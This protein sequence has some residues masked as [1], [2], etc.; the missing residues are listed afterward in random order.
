MA[1]KSVTNLRSADKLVEEAVEFFKSVSEIKYELAKDAY[2]AQ[3]EETKAVIDRIHDTLRV[4]ASGYIT[5]QLSPPSGDLVPVKIDND[6]LTYNL[7]WL[8]VEIIK[9][10]AI[11]GTRVANFEF[12]PSM[13]AI[14]GSEII[15]EKT[16]GRKV[17]RG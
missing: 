10:L 11:L 6:Y 2:D 13:C 12:P 17:G 4:Y 1:R 15:P 8:A 16:S 9:D 7:L 3:D 5:V 14:C